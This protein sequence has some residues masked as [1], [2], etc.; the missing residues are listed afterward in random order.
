MDGWKDGLIAA[1]KSHSSDRQQRQHVT[2]EMYQQIWALSL[3][4]Y[5]FLLIGV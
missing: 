4:A 2:Q 3:L 1:W 5:G